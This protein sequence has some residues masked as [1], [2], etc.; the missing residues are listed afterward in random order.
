MDAAPREKETPLAACLARGVMRALADL[1][2]ESLSEFRVGKGR[3]VDVMGLDRDGRFVAVE[4]KTSEADFRAD[5]KW[6]DYL[7]YCDAFYFAVP[8][9]FPRLILPEAHGLMVA[10]EFAAAVLREAPSH[11]LNPARRRAQILRFARTAGSRLR[12]GADPS[13]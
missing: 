7:P 5:G 3:R 6:H 11:R 1:G 13:L 9:G 8:E 4:I 10:D 2:Y 12:H